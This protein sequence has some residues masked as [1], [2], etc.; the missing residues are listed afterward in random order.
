MALRLAG[1]PADA[2]QLRRAR[3]YILANGGIES[4]RVFTRIWLALFG[5]W[6]WHRLPAIPPEVVLLPPGCRS[7]STTS[8]AGPGRPSCRW[9]LSG[10]CGRYGRSASRSDELRTG[11]RPARRAVTAAPGRLAAPPRRGAARLRATADRPAAPQRA[12][13]RRGV[14]RGPAGGGRLLGRHPATLGLLADRAAP[15]RLS[16]RP[17]GARRP[18]W[19]AWSASP[20]GRRPRRARCAGWRRASRRSGTPRWR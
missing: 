10:R 14:D 18:V 17:P 4:S 15:A 12:A 13:P 20:Y 7:T 2:E 3:R 19:P 8:P 5:Q 16:A 1:D 11:R 9:R 6:P